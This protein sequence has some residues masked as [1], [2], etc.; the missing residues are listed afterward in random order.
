[1][2]HHPE[3][4]LEPDHG[5]DCCAVLSL[6]ERDDLQSRLEAEQLR[7]DTHLRHCNELSSRLDSVTAL[8]EARGNEMLKQ[9]GELSAERSARI[10][11]ES[12]LE[13]SRCLGSPDGRCQIRRAQE[14]AGDPREA[15]VI[16]A[17]GVEKLNII[18]EP[19]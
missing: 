3:C 4:G 18:G 2:S 12:R 9:D 14:F 13:A 5:G 7:A 6:K 19:K 8:A 16:S 10:A 11:A 15:V 1:M 17:S